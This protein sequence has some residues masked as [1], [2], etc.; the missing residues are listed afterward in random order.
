MLPG[1]QHFAIFG[2]L[3][4]LLAGAQ[5]ILGVDIFESDEDADHAGS[6]GFFDEM[7]QA[8]THGVDLNDELDVELFP[9]A[10]LNDAIEDQFP[11]GV[12]GEVVVGDEEPV[13]ALGEVLADDLLDVVG[14]AAAGFPALDVDD[15][16]E[17]AEEGAAPAG[18]ET[19]D[20]S[21]G[22]LDAGGGKHGE[23]GA[24]ER[25]QIV[26]EIVDGLEPAVPGVEED[27]V[28]A[29]FGFAGEQQNAEIQGF[30]QFGR[31][32]GEHG[33]AAG[34][35]ESADGDLD[36]RG[37]QLAGKIEGAGIL[38]RL[39]ADQGDQ[40]SGA[41][42]FKLSQSAGD[43]IHAK[44]GVGFIT[45]GDVDFDVVAQQAARFRIQGEAVHDGEGIRGD[46]G[47]KPLN[48]VAIVVVVGGFDEDQLK[49][50]HDWT[51]L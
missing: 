9:L 36:V 1:E 13:D 35:V 18:V 41:F 38:I 47:A 43:F 24:G 16:A 4:L 22:A 33:E 49:S 27:G 28:E 26:H 44:A 6:L 29:A 30:L 3:V 32:G 10:Q 20:L 34:D 45:G 2:D 25:R 7:R 21:A 17:G 11:I 50:S 14:G 40:R 8:M 39:D 5:E 23:G 37:A 19:G 31:D 12:A 15:G 51:L 46:G 48:Q 42:F